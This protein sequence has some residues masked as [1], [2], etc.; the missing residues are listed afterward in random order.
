MQPNCGQIQS[1]NGKKTK[2]WRDGEIA[3]DWRKGRGRADRAAGERVPHAPNGS[4]ARGTNFASVRAQWWPPG[5]G[6]NDVPPGVGQ[7]GGGGAKL[8]LSLQQRL[9]RHPTSGTR[10]VRTIRTRKVRLKFM[11]APSVRG[12]SVGRGIERGRLH[13]EPRSNR[14]PS[15]DGARPTN[16]IFKCRAGLRH[17]RR[18][19]EQNR[20]VFGDVW[21]IVRV[22]PTARMRE[23]GRK[24]AVV[25]VVRT[26]EDG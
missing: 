15:A 19:L 4:A 24:V 13:R 10:R 7:H 1:E 6:L 14:R 16:W 25:S 22:A 21:A 12:P 9:R 8:L 11:V 3:P 18:R 20:D 23:V 2:C 17:T 26:E 5:G